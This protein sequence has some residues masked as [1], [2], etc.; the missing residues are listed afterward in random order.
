M[1]RLERD[2]WSMVKFLKQATNKYA[3]PPLTP[4]A[5]FVFVH[6]IAPVV[7]SGTFFFVFFLGRNAVVRPVDV[8]CWCFFRDG[9]RARLH[10]SHSPPRSGGGIL[11]LV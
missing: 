5:V 2:A 4:P 3:P 8:F 9:T 7:A 1:L 6:L 11:E 10:A